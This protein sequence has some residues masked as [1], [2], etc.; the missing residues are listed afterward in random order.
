MI[1]SEETMTRTPRSRRSHTATGPAA[2]GMLVLILLSA[3][4]LA[5]VDRTPTARPAPTTDAPTMRAVPWNPGPV[6]GEPLT[7]PFPRLGMW[8]PD[9]WEQPL[10][11]IARYDWVIL[12][13]WASEF[14]TP[15]KALNPE[16]LL[17]NSTN[18]C[19]LSYD[20]DPGAEPWANEK[21]RAIPPGWFLTQ[22]GTTLA[23]DVNTTTTILHVAEITATNG[24]STCALFVVSDTVLIQG[25]SAFVEAVDPAARTLTVR[26]GYVRPAAPHAAGA[27]VAA[28]ITFWPDSWLLNLSTLCPSATVSPTVGPENWAQY[29]ARVAIGLLSHP[30]WDG[31]LIDRSDPDESWLIGNSTARTI[32]PD[33]SNTLL[34]D[35]V[36]FDQSWNEGLRRYE[37]IV[38]DTIGP[39]RIVF[40][41]WGMANYDLLNGNNLEGFPMDDG[42]AYGTPWHQMVFGPAENGSYFEWVEQALQPNL[43]MIETYEQDGGPDPVGG[44]EYENPCDDPDF[45][46]NYRKM[47][48]GLGT[49]LLNDGF[50][51]YEIN[52][53]GHG[54]LCLLWFDEYDNA[55]QGRGY[56]GLPLGPAHRAID[57]LPTPNLVGGGDFEH[58]DDLDGWDLW[59]DTG[60]GYSATLSLDS[61]TAAS[62][63]TSVRVEVT[64][65]GGT[66]WQVSLSAEPVEIISGTEYTLAFWARADRDRTIDAWAQQTSPP[67]DT[68]LWYGSLPLSTTWRLYE[69]AAVAAG[70]DP[71]A[72]MHFGLGTTT[73]AVWLDGVRLQAGSR[74]IW[75]RDYGGG[76]AL[77]NA[78]AITQTLELGATYRRISGTQ[79]PTVNDGSLVTQVDLPPLD[80]LILLRHLEPRIYLPLVLKG[81]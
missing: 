1:R 69:I 39:E 60:E 70:S 58:P 49:A 78:T 15:L 47:R 8:W 66:A 44:G 9:P 6:A 46:P 57:V 54:S 30:G 11:D 79:V 41:N 67:W 10:G 5:C 36:A 81:M 32:D 48:F 35:Y 72:G 29:N 24:I 23:T 2:R 55:G 26:R 31:L 77:V 74:N 52:T 19:E 43:T 73:G 40:V 80:G 75:R 65:A 22:V 76:L 61:S 62:G 28:H 18:A 45:V 33:Q 53:D 14:I 51:S 50:F 42:T 25:E 4:L 71:Q 68:Y 3:S 20:P 16:L 37:Q 59:A 63:T 38:R 27:R 64:Q 17:L 13:D 12:G 34:S 7:L 21:V 56:L